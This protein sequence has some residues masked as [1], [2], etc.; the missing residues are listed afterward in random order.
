M[1]NFSTIRNKPNNI[2]IESVF[3]NNLNWYSSRQNSVAKRIIYKL[4]SD[5]FNEENHPEIF[6]WM[7]EHFDKLVEALKCAEI[8]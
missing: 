8:I 6:S 2:D 3:G 4:E 5:Y 1:T 7:V